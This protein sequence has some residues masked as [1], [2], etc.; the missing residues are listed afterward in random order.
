MF[1]IPDRSNP[2][3][4]KIVSS[5]ERQGKN[6]PIQGT[7]ADITKYAL[8]YIYNEIVKRKLDAFLILNVHDEIVAEAREDVVDEVAKIVEDNMIKAWRKLIKTV[9]IKVDVFISS[10]WE[11]G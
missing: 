2:D 9:P 11:K 3:F 6:M 10:V 8:V 1:T 7:S 4:E 5:I